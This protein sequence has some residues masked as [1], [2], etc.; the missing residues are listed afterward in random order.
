MKD[1]LIKSLI[2]VTTL[3]VISLVFIFA[4]TL[5]LLSFIIVVLLSLF[6][7]LGMVY[8]LMNFIEEKERKD[9]DKDLIS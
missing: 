9:R 7:I 1:L 5:P 6:V 4:E 8:R 3:A 2:T